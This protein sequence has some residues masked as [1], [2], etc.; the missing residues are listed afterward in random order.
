MCRKA[1]RSPEARAQ[2]DL[3]RRADPIVRAARDLAYEPIS[4]VEARDRLG[5]RIGDAEAAREAIEM[6][7]VGRDSFVKD[8]A[9]RLLTAAVGREDVRPIDPAVREAFQREEALGRM[10]L[11]EAFAHLAE[12]EPDLTQAAEAEPLIGRS[13]RMRELVGLQARS[14]DPLL[15]SDVAAS[16]VSQ[17]VGIRKGLLR[18]I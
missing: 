15:R 7:S 8:R 12:L 2:L 10:P 16:V 18:A 13:D 3:I 6:L 14:G 1:I 11:N 9:Y 4:D 5:A 17:Y